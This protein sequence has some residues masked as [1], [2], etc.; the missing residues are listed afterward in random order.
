MEYTF[1]LLVVFL[2]FVFV[3][4]KLVKL[5]MKI[6]LVIFVS[7]AFPVVAYYFKIIPNLSIEIILFFAT[8]GLALYVLFLLSKGLLD[9]VFFLLGLILWPFKKILGMDSKD[10]K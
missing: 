8:L 7:A 6:L 3:A 5:V 10:S 9:A 1:A 4:Y 2:L